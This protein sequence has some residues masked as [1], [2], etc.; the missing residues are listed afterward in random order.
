MYVIE[1]KAFGYQLL[2]GGRVSGS[3]MRAWLAESIEALA[4]APPSFGVFV[5]MRTL[6]PLGDEARVLL[7]RGQRLYSKAGMQRSV[8]ILDT[9]DHGVHWQRIAQQSGIWPNE[10][11]ID[12]STNADW[13][14]DGLAWIIDGIEPDGQL[15]LT[16]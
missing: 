1:K 5:D 16:S 9:A 14:A 4:T 7:L 15:R 2:F 8:V 6:R 11:Y 12:A 13:N 10:R 3:Q